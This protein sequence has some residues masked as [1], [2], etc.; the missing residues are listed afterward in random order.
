MNGLGTINIYS[1]LS[2]SGYPAVEDKIYS[3]PR[4]KRNSAELSLLRTLNEVP[5]VSATTRVDCT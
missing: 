3:D 2:A 1:Q 4:Q 5:R